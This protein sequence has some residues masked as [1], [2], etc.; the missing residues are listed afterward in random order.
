MKTL[1][2]TYVN[3]TQRTSKAGKPFTSISIKATEYGDKYISGFGGKAN[4]GWKA[5]DTVEVL[6]VIQKGQ[7]LNFEML[8]AQ[9][10][11][12]NVEVMALSHKLDLIGSQLRS[13]IE[14]LS[15]TNRLDRNSDGSKSPDFS[16]QDDGLDYINPEDFPN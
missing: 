6:D 13:V 8:K 12:N 7:Y 1:N 9:A 5:G 2:L 16:P 15:G 3:R 10:V 14:H 11:N 4:E